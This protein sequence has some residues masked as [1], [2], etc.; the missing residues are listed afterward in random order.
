MH[1]RYTMQ[2]GS[3][4]LDCGNRSDVLLEFLIYELILNRFEMPP[5]FGPRILCIQFQHQ[6]RV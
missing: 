6:P 2:L 3:R 5:I 4:L 1:S